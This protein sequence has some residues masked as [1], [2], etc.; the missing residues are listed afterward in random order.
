MFYENVYIYMYLERAPVPWTV[1]IWV[2]AKTGAGGGA[3]AGWG[4]VQP[5]LRCGFASSS[6]EREHLGILNWTSCK[7]V[8]VY[9]S[10]E[11]AGS[12]TK[13]S[14]H[15]QVEVTEKLCRYS[16]SCINL[17]EGK[18]LLT[19]FKAVGKSTGSEH[20]QQDR[21]SQLSEQEAI[22]T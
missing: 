15:L 4:T 12:G 19:L 21:F 9:S 18:W 10:C 5:A 13:C 1:S 17:C 2:T 11:Q 22:I 16:T 20:H 6:S 8:F 3:A 7:W 14:V